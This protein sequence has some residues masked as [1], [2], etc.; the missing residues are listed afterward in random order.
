VYMPRANGFE[1]TR[2]IM[3]TCPAP[4][5]M[6]S[7]GVS[8]D[9][10][11]LTFEALSAGALAIVE[12]PPGRRAPNQR[13]GAQRL[14]DMVKGMAEVRVVRRT[15]HPRIPI[16]APPKPASVESQ[17]RI[18]GIGASTGG[19]QTIAAILKELPGDLRAPLLVVQHIVP[20][21]LDGMA[22]WL[23]ELTPLSVS[24]AKAGVLVR[25][26]GCYLGPNG[27]HLGITSGGQI[28]L[29]ADTT[30]SAFC[31]SVSRLFESIADSY[32]SSAMGVLL[33][34]MGSDGASGLARLHA[35][36]ATTVAQDE[37]SSPIFGMPAKAIALGAAKHVLPPDGIAALI[38][39][40]ASEGER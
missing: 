13:E 20:G 9:E 22:D 32:G 30:G 18:I 6:A 10:V 26:G 21:F 1:A 38:R 7:A 2:Q 5:V 17:V 14:R 11:A 37:A 25:P 31:P 35:C 12:K 24:V 36:G 4:I 34:G 15:L 19:P 23:N 39:S 3:G 8:R 27:F 33:T 16:A 40:V 28:Q 29:T